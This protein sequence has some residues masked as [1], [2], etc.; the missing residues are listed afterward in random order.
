MYHAG[1]EVKVAMP[2]IA[3]TLAG[4]ESEDGA[5][6]TN[7]MSAVCADAAWE[8]AEEGSEAVRE[9]TREATAAV[10]EL[11]CDWICEWRLVG[12]W[13]REGV[14]GWAYVEDVDVWG[15]DGNDDEV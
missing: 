5:V 6:A 2:P 3:V 7:F 1:V 13:E 10:R 14:E 9:F 15:W 8:R 11:Y 4:M 12:G